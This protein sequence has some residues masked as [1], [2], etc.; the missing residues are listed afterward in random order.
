[1]NSLGRWVEIA[2]GGRAFVPSPLPRGIALSPDL[3]RKI[4][5][6]RTLLGRLAEGL[7]ALPRPELLLRPF[8]TR[9]AAIAYA[10]RN[11]I[12]FRVSEPKESKRRRVAYSDNF[13]FDRRQPWTH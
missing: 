5:D 3:I 6:A 12:A 10:T 2:G 9:E 8:E 7:R 13:R 1:M 11:G 4:G